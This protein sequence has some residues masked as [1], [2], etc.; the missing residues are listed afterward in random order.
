[1]SSTLRITVAT[2]CTLTALGIIIVVFTLLHPV[3]LLP[4]MQATPAPFKVN[5]LVAAHSLPAGTLVRE[6]DFVAK[7]MP[8]INGGDAD[9][10]DSPEA[11]AGLRGA[12]VRRFIDAGTPMVADDFLRPRDRGFIASVLEPGMVAATIG[13]DA[14]SGVGGLIWPGDHVNVLLDRKSVV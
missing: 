13:V 8:P 11:R 7:P 12:L 6:E 9:L 3:T 4:V 2:L 10:T 14:I 5:Y 1:M